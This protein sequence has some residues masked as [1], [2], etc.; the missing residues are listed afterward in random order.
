MESS[1][2][3]H[4]FFTGHLLDSSTSCWLRIVWILHWLKQEIE[5]QHWRTY[6]S[7]TRKCTRNFSI[8]NLWDKMTES[9]ILE[10]RW[11]LHFI[12]GPQDAFLWRFYRFSSIRTRNIE[13]MKN[14]TK[15]ALFEKYL[16]IYAARIRYESADVTQMNEK[17]RRNLI[18]L[19]SKSSDVSDQWQDTQIVNYKRSLSFSGNLIILIL[20]CTSDLFEGRREILIS[21][22]SFHRMSVPTYILEAVKSVFVEL[23]KTSKRSTENPS[24]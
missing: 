17:R 23:F 22:L 8:E 14:F 1:R 12:N 21:T 7:K 19:D 3:F 20:T 5:D 2:K 13:M 10:I 15:F 4:H 6:L 9:S 16:N 24:L 11:G 18:I